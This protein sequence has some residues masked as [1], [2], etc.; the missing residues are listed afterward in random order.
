MGR[1][2][3]TRYRP[4]ENVCVGKVDRN[5]AVGVSGGV[6]FENDPSVIPV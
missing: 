2:R 6:I 4:R 1:R 5:V 3:S